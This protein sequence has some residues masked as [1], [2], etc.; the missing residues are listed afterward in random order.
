MTAA[1]TPLHAI[2]PPR[3]LL[4]LCGLISDSRA[5]AMGIAGAGAA[6]RCIFGKRTA[7]RLEE[8]LIN[9]L[10]YPFYKAGVHYNIH[11]LG[12]QMRVRNAHSPFRPV[13]KRSPQAHA[14]PLRIGMVGEMSIGAA[15]PLALISEFPT[16]HVFHVFDTGREGVFGELPQRPN[17]VVTRIALPENASGVEKKPG[18]VAKYVPAV[19]RL[20]TAINAARLDLLIVSNGSIEEKHDIAA[21][22]DTPCLVGYLMGSEPV[23]HPKI[24]YC[25]YVQPRTG[26]PVL[27]HTMYSVFTGRPVPAEKCCTETAFAYEMVGAD[28]AAN[29]PW[30]ARE[31][32]MIFHGRLAQLI[33]PSFLGVL[34][35]LLREDPGLR[36]ELLGPGDNLEEIQAFFA[37]RGVGE[38]VRYLGMVDK[39]DYTAGTFHS[40]IYDFVRRGRLEANPWPI[41]GGSARV[42]AYLA[43]TPTANLRFHPE[44]DRPWA[45]D[46][47]TVALPFIDAPSGTADDIAGFKA[48]CRRCLYDRTFA[49]E[50]IAEQYHVAAEVTNHGVWWERVIACYRDW[51]AGKGWAAPEGGK[52]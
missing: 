48:L 22:V 36:F 26:F 16:G 20:A 11:A 8:L 18:D 9:A 24:D 30:E 37:N 3:P 21:L 43:G 19:H 15:R 23:M 7:G 25:L 5:A 29:P 39:R 47:T 52:A 40:R 27:G 44:G 38:R 31:N 34:A 6:A 13:P 1:P 46:Q 51:L 10:S 33:E 50:L 35:E 12:L 17:V 42:E 41:G 49:E 14:G 4:R 28:R 2:R 45:S 32:L